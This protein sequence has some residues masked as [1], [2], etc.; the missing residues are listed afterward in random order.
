VIFN[1]VDIN[2]KWLIL[3]SFTY[4]LLNIYH[5]PTIEPVMKIHSS[6]SQGACAVVVT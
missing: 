1:E 2:I 3:Y 4:H 5:V 6:L